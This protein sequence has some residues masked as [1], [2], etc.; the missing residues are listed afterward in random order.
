MN[1]TTITTNHT[2]ATTSVPKR[3]IFA[4]GGLA[5]LAAAIV[6]AV[7]GD[8]WAVAA[9]VIFVLAPDLTLLPERARPARRPVPVVASPSRR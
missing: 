9:M 6:A 2:H 1:A 8:G 4:V 5:A 3:V 7:R